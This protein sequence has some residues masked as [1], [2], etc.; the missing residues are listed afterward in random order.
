VFLVGIFLHCRIAPDLV[1]CED[2]LLRAPVVSIGLDERL[3]VGAFLRQHAIAVHV[4]D[5]VLGRQGRIEL[6]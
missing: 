1:G 4:L 6:G 3:D 5:R 2:V